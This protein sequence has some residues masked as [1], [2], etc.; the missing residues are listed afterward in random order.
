[1]KEPVKSAYIGF[2][3]KCKS[4][5]KKLLPFPELLVQ[6]DERHNGYREQLKKAKSG[7]TKSSKPTE[8]ERFELLCSDAAVE[9]QELAKELKKAFDTKKE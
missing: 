6:Y 1:M 8:I 7:L 5:R 4:Y 2:N 9:M 3:E